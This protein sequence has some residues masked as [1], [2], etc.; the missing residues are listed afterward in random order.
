MHKLEFSNLVKRLIQQNGLSKTAL[1]TK[2]QIS[3]TSLYKLL[4]GD[5]AEAKLSTIINLSHA[6]EIPPLELLKPYFKQLAAA[7]PVVKDCLTLN[8]KFIA[9]LTYPDNAIVYTG[10]TFDKVWSVVNTGE[11]AWKDLFLECQDELVYLDKNRYLEDIPIGL[12]PEKRRVA[13]PETLP[14]E[15]AIISVTF[16][17]PH[18]PATA[19]SYWKAVNVDGELIF[20][21]KKPLYCMVKIVGL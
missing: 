18:L 7:S 4:N 5:V 21:H 16:N 13:I 17:A 1:S 11:V 2:A 8:T 3:R 9:D 15:K 20:P 12:H 6:L 14:G 19:I 10:Q